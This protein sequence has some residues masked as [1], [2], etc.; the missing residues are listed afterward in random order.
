MKKCL[1]DA[2]R[3]LCDRGKL[4]AAAAIA[5]ASFHEERMTTAKVNRASPICA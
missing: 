3:M 5:A 4:A 2:T 1:P